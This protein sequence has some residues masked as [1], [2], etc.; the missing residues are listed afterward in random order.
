M[1]FRFF[2]YIESKVNVSLVGALFVLALID[3]TFRVAVWRESVVDRAG[4][5]S[6]KVPPAVDSPD[7]VIERI[8]RWVPLAANANQ[9]VSISPDA[10]VLRAVAVSRGD[11]R[12]VIA[13]TGSDGQV[14]RYV[15]LRVGDVLEGWQV[16]DIQSRKVY[17]RQE[18]RSYELTIFKGSA[19]AIGSGGV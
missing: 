9:A 10:F 12:A 5:T 3:F 17:L 15:R 13:L 2:E 18:D 11:N 8:Q 14:L 19:A 7:K 16:A 1:K 6:L 4:A